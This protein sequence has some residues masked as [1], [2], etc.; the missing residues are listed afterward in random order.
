L[1][2]N[3]KRLSKRRLPLWIWLT[4]P[5]LVG[6]LI[7]WLAL[8]WGI[9]PAAAKD[10]QPSD[11]RTAEREAYLTMVAESFAADG[12]LAPAR[13]KVVSWSNDALEA[14]LGRLQARLSTEDALQAGDLR[15]LAAALGLRLAATPAVSTTAPVDLTRTENI[16]VLGSDNRPDME[17]WRTDSIMVVVIDPKVGQVGIV[18]IPR[19]LYVDVP[20][21]DKG[22]ERLNAVAYIGETLDYPGGGPALVRRV[23]E[24]Q[25][26]IPTQHYVIIH[27][28]GLIKLVDALGGVT[29][30]LDCPLYEAT[31]D[32]KSPTGIRIFTLPAGQVQLDG[33]TAKKFA[34]Y[35]YVETDFGRTRRQQQLI[36]AIRNRVLQAN[37]LPKIPE[38][39]RALS[40]TFTTDL[41]LPSVLKLARL[42]SRLQARDVHGMQ[43]GTDTIEQYTTPEGWM[44]LVLKDKALLQEKL[45]GIFSSQSLS[46]TG[47]GGTADGEC[48]PSPFEN[49]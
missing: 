34:T 12:K 25:L 26:G 4:L 29:V 37:L 28:D 21:Y 35:R 43:L 16:L 23:V 30:N 17:A 41:D 31:P 48:P 44:V 6:L 13:E 9:W 42:A 39:W 20:D 40:D 1:Q 14:D 36:W 27:Q 18:S 22:K 15:A 32:A 47:K 19:D 33:A 10:M 3:L 11:L 46:Q 24:E 5:F 7:G 38:L 8:G 2:R 45:A 49:Q